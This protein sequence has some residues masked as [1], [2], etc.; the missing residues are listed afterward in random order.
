MIAQILD[1]RLVQLT[2]AHRVTYSRYADDLTFSTNERVFPAALAYRDAAPGS[3]W[4]LG[5]DLVGII[6]KAGFAERDVLAVL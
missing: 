2:K 6:E 1:V 4:I 3:D 5:R